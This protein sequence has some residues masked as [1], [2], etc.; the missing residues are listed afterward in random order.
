MSPAEPT[1]SEVKVY[2]DAP[3][4]SIRWEGKASRMVVEWKAWATSDEF[5]AAYDTIIAAIRE[6]RATRLLIDLRKTRVLAEEDQK[7]LAEDW[8]PRSVQAGLRSAVS[9][10]GRYAQRHPC[11]FGNV[12]AACRARPARLGAGPG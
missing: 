2:L 1:Q 9:V 8:V 6:N 12:F 3:Y 4:L 5:R 7:W 10:L 11:G